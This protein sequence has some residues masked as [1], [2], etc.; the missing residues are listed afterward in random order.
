MPLE[1]N[2]KQTAQAEGADFARQA[3]TGQTGFLQEVWLFLRANKKWWL[4]PLLVILLV[5]GA[6]VALGGTAVAPFIYTLF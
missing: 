3:S 1:P 5:F 6:L 4:T 2:A